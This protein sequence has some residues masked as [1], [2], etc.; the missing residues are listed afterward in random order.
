MLKRPND[1]DKT[2]PDQTNNLSRPYASRARLEGTGRFAAQSAVVGRDPSPYPAQPAGSPW[3]SDPVPPEEPLGESVED[4]IPVG[5]ACGAGGEYRAPRTRRGRAMISPA[6]DE[7]F[8]IARRI[9]PSNYLPE[10]ADVPEA[11]RANVLRDNDR[12]ERGGV[13][14]PEAIDIWFRTQ[15]AICTSLTTTQTLRDGPSTP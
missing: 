4:V 7:I 1:N 14:G 3:A 12:F 5:D 11:H 9:I 6:L 15:E 2:P 10:P 13:S 8:A